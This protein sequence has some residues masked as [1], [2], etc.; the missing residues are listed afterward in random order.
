MN[1]DELIA[2]V[3]ILQIKIKA[4]E[5]RVREIETNL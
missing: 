4:L 2:T 5:I 3:E 1:L